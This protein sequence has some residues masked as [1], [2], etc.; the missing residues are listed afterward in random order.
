MQ[1][2]ATEAE[3]RALRAQ[4]NPFLF[5]ALT[6]IGYLIQNAPPLSS[7]LMKLTSCCT[8]SCPLDRRGS[9]RSTTKSSS[10]ALIWTSEGAF[11]TA[12]RDDRRSAREF[13]TC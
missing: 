12:A 5:N 7:T 13:A 10:C 2:L 1:R 8:G 9:R 11:R 6:T 3:L 4:L